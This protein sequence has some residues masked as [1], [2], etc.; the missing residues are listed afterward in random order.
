M[1]R[2]T[3]LIKVGPPSLFGLPQ[4][5]MTVLNGKLGGKLQGPTLDSKSGH[6]VS[7]GRLSEYRREEETVR[8]SGSVGGLP[9]TVRDNFFTL[10]VD[11]SD[12]ATALRLG[13]ARFELFLRL[14]SL[15]YGNAFSYEVLHIESPDGDLE[16]S[17]GPKMVEL[18]RATMFN[19]EQLIGHIATAAA[20]AQLDDPRLSKSLMYREHAAFLFETRMRVGFFTPHFSFLLTSAYLNIWKAI[21]TIL[22]DPSIDSD[23]QSRFKKFGL[24]KGYWDDT[25]KPLKKIRDDVDVA[26][27]SL[28]TDTIE[29]VEGAFGAA[30]QVCKVVVKAYVGHLN[31]TPNPL[32]PT[33][34]GQA[35]VE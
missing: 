15:E 28:A 14:L 23:Y 7:Y 29:I 18:F 13:V 24:P 17:P 2:F 33:S 21:A 11:A 25:V 8:F 20:S 4:D 19:T 1:K 27:Y 5:G 16:V 31:S 22:G 32:Q 26:H 30:G 34:G 3:L 12:R 6:F 9:L 10:G 35:G